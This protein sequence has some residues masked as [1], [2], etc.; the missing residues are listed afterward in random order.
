MLV[1]P[2]WPHRGEGIAEGKPG[3][4]KTKQD[5]R[6]LPTLNLGPHSPSYKLPGLEFTF[7]Q[8]RPL[9]PVDCQPLSQVPQPLGASTV[10]GTQWALVL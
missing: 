1:Y 4:R 5:W 7:L 3:G 9:L 6:S 8:T 10:P 2:L